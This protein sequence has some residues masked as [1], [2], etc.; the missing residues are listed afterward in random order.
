MRQA[1]SLL[2]DNEGEFI[3]V[4][5]ERLKLA[6]YSVTTCYKA[7]DASKEVQHNNLEQANG[8]ILL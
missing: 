2:L 8:C 4:L 1:C 3:D 5:H 7:E 6:G